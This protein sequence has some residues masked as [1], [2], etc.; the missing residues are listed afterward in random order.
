MATVGSMPPKAKYQ[1]CMVHFM[2]NVL[3]KTPPGHREW[4]STALKAV[5]AMESR[6]SDL[7]KA[8]TVAAEMESRKLKAA[9]NC[10]REGIGETTTYL[11]ARVSRGAPQAHPHEQHDRTAQPGDQAAHARGRRLPRREQRAHAR[12]RTHQV[13]HR[14]RMVDPPLPRHAPAR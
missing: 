3:S 10:L 14:E 7:T 8:E 4:A 12:L 5:F 13:R 2:R 1:R 6:E 9:S 11:L